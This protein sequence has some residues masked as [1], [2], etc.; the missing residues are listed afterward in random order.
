M[1]IPASYSKT[2]KA[3]AKEVL[4]TCISLGVTVEGKEPKEILKELEEGNYESLFN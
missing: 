2:A 3:A 4:G 1:K